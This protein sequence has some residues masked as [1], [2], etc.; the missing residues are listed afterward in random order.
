MKNLKFL[1][2]NVLTAGDIKAVAQHLGE[3]LSMVFYLLETL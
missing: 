2:G 1:I 3:E